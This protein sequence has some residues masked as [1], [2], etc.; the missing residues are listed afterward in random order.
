VNITITALKNKSRKIKDFRHH[1]WGLVHPKH[2]GTNQDANFW[3]KRKFIFKAEERKQIVGVIQGDWVA[4]VMYIDQLIVKS[5]WVGKGIGKALMLK[6]EN[7]AS[8]NNLHKI[9]LNTGVNW[10]AVG[11]YESLGYKKEG[12]ISNFYEHKNFWYMSKELK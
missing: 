8:E 2:F 1:E 3:K 10:K 5:D 12:K 7:L 11:F 6:A 4:G 9:Y